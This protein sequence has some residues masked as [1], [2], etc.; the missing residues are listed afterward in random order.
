MNDRCHI[1]IKAENLV[2]TEYLVNGVCK[3]KVTEYLSA[4]VKVSSDIQHHLPGFLD[5]DYQN[6]MQEAVEGDTVNRTTDVS[7]SQVLF[8]VK[9]KREDYHFH[10]MTTE[11]KKSLRQYLP[12]YITP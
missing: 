4:P 10:R 2:K 1:C 9:A 7:K 8:A 12:T 11:V 3:F 5:Y 6:K